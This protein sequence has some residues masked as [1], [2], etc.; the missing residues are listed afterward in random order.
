MLFCTSKC[1]KPHLSIIRARIVFHVGMAVLRK[2]I[3]FHHEDILSSC[4]I[5][6]LVVLCAAGVIYSG[7]F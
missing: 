3:F 1:Q 4:A 2:L 7:P 5:S 6:T